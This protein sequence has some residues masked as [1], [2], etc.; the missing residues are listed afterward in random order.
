MRFFGTTELA[1]GVLELRELF[2]RQDVHAGAFHEV[3]ERTPRGHQEER[4]RE[5]TR[6]L[7][8]H[9]RIP[10]LL[11]HGARV[12]SGRI[13]VIALE[14]FDRALNLLAQRIVVDRRRDEAERLVVLVREQ[15]AEDA[16]EDVPRRER[17]LA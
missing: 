9:P 12:A 6:R 16:H 5:Q 4:V 15:E 11:E 17:A 10:R 1:R 14:R 13:A 2:V 3:H 8:A 7:C